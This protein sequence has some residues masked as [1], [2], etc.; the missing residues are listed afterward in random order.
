[1]TYWLVIVKPVLFLF[2]AAALTSAAI[3]ASLRIDTGLITGTATTSPEIRVFKGIPFA[4]P[5]VGDPRRRYKNFAAN[6]E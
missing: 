5:P 6:S 1:M 4:A 3:P 2:A